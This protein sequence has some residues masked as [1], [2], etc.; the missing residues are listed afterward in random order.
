MSSVGALG[1]VTS[2]LSPGAP[3]CEIGLTASALTS[4]GPVPNSKD[5]QEL[6]PSTWH[7]G[8][9]GLSLLLTSSSLRRMTD[10]LFWELL[11]VG[12]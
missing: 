2:P 8:G 4:G 12:G 5:V 9:A 3:I 6:K 1:A 7:V 10:V 11:W